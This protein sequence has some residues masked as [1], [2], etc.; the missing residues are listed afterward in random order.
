MFA[1]QRQG[2]IVALV[3]EKGAVRIGELTRLFSVSVETI[4]R[5]LMELEKQNCLRRVHGGAMR[6]PRN[7]EYPDRRERAER[8][9]AGKAELV[10]NAAGLI[11]EN[12][13]I[14]VD[15]GSTA[16]AFAGMLAERFEKLTVIT[17]ALDV[18]EA[19][20]QKERYELYLCSGFFM[21]RENAFYGPWVLE[22]LDRF[23]AGTAFVFPSAVS[24]QYGIMDYDRDLY[25]VQRKMMERSDRTVF[26]A[27]SGKF[28][29]SGLLKLADAG[30]GCAIVTD[31]ALE[32]EIFQLYQENQICVHRGQKHEG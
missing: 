31:G 13:T 12:D 22:A 30:E 16:V 18:F 17:N 2:Q 8:N 27:D 10:R 32:D 7:G 3:N 5:D 23:H 29:K 11:R 14:M 28:E 26:C 9:R 4:R 25:A 24:M 15:C 19:L 1:T 6:I 20:R 21:G